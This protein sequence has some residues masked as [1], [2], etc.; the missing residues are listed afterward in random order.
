MDGTLVT[1][2]GLSPVEGS[3]VV[4][5]IA[6][7]CRRFDGTLTLLWHNSSL[8][9]ARERDWYENMVAAVM[10]PTGPPARVPS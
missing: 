10:S 6:R 5:E 3:D 9:T 1:Y 8:V 4:L 2:M 7:Q